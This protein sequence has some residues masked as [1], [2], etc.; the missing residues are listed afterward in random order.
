VP[1]FRSPILTFYNERLYEKNLRLPESEYKEKVERRTAG[2]NA[3]IS[4]VTDNSTCRSVSLL[5]YFGQQESAPCGKCD[6]CIEKKK[7]IM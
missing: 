2:V 7:L 5:R 1:K 6:I 4:L 3:M